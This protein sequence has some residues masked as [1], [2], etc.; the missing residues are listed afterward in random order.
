MNR[1]V[2]PIPSASENLEQN[3]A[4]SQFRENAEE[5]LEDP[6]TFIAYPVFDTFEDDRKLAGVLATN[7]YWKLFFAGILP[8][9][10]TGFVCVL[11]NSFNQTLS[12]RLD[13]ERVTYLGEEDRHDPEYDHLEA[14]AD[15]NSYIESR[16]RAETR[17]YTTVSLNKEYGKYTLRIY[18]SS[19]TE[20]N[21]ISNDPWVYT[22]ACMAIFFLQ[23]TC[24]SYFCLG[25]GEKTEHCYGASY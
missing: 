23:C 13:G 10:A 25:C 11:E 7:V 15:I 3:L 5:Y 9:T 22:S 18:P 16:A 12:Y 2:I 24:F 14:S 17:S 21:Y 8:S 1:A 6:L 19:A 4:L 20:E